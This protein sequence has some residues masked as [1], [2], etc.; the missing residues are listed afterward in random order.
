MNTFKSLVQI[1]PSVSG[2]EF[3]MIRPVLLL[4]PIKF[5]ELQ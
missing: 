3:K 4:N 5:V 2:G 1:K